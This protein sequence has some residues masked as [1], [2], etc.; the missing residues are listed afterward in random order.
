M[1]SAGTIIALKLDYPSLTYRLKER[2]NGDCML[3]ERVP[4]ENY[5]FMRYISKPKPTPKTAAIKTTADT[6]IAGEGTSAVS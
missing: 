2:A 4:L 3:L 1:V 5:R 6:Q